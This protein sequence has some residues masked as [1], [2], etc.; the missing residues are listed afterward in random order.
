[1]RLQLLKCF[2]IFIRKY[3]LC[4]LSNHLPYLFKACQHVIMYWYLIRT[5]SQSMECLRLFMIGRVYSSDQRRT[6]TADKPASNNQYTS[7]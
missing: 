6:D 5:E 2:K 4:E 1:M 3:D 7:R